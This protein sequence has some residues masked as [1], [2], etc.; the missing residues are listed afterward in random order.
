M[1]K[2]R[3]YHDNSGFGSLYKALAIGGSVIAAGGIFYLGAVNGDRIAVKA[4]KAK[5][6]TGSNIYEPWGELKMTESQAKNPW[7]VISKCAKDLGQN[8]EDLRENISKKYRETHKDKTGKV[9]ELKWGA[10]YENF[11]LPLP[12]ACIDKYKKSEDDIT[13]LIIQNSTPAPPVM[14]R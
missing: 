5:I 12:Q 13:P 8:P 14:P 7:G 9:E 10:L 11:S 6:I 2:I 3:S 4:E 1:R